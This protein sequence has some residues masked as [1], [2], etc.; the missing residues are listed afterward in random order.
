MSL[1]LIQRFP[2]LVYQSDSFNLEI[3]LKEPGLIF[4]QIKG[5]LNLKSAQTIVEHLQ[6]FQ[7]I[8]AA[9]EQMAFLIIQ[10]KISAKYNIPARA[11]LLR[12]LRW[13]STGRIYGVYC[14]SQLVFVRRVLKLIAQFNPQTLFHIFESLEQAQAAVEAKK[15][16]LAEDALG[17]LQQ[18]WN[19]RKSYRFMQNRPRCEIR[20]YQPYAHFTYVRLVGHIGLPAL[21]AVLPTFKVILDQLAEQQNGTLVLDIRQIQG[22]DPKVLFIPGIRQ[23]TKAVNKVL[24]HFVASDSQVRMIRLLRFIRP[25]RYKHALVFS[26]P[27][28]VFR[29]LFNERTALPGSDLSPLVA[30]TTATEI[31]KTPDLAALLLEQQAVIEEQ[32]VSYLEQTENLKQVLLRVLNHE[33]DQALEIQLPEHNSPLNEIFELVEMLHTDQFQM[34]NDLQYQIEKRSEAQQ[35][36]LKASQIKSQFLATVSHELRTPLNAILGFT[37]VLKRAQENFSDD[38]QLYLERIASNSAHLL[39]VVNQLLDLARIESQKL[40]L[41]PEKLN[42]RALV[43]AVLE[44]T[45][46]LVQN[47]SLEIELEIANTLYLNT[48]AQSFKQIL[49]NI[50]HNAIKYTPRGI[51]YLRAISQANQQWILQIQDTGTGISADMQGSVFEA[52]T[53]SDTQNDGVGLGLAISHSLCQLLGYKLSL[54]ESNPQGTTFEIELGVLDIDSL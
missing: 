7:K 18:V 49:L 45:E 13:K 24:S 21:D 48:D 37:H 20:F 33:G 30:E 15:T 10:I 54:S 11:Y 51:I 29:K 3:K 39:Q 26:S 28:E 19:E 44:Q 50:L 46:V 22:F 53:S 52:F 41:V 5:Q 16:E 38:Q 27:Q 36:A 23:E 8:I 40:A 17:Q 31:E 34:I 43:Q 9:Q 6:D 35:E 47:K 42:L 25:S 14:I 1:D 2:T 12:H 4:F 32:Q